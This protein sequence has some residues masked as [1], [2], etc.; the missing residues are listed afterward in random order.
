MPGGG[1]KGEASRDPPGS[2]RDRQ[3]PR[4]RDGAVFR[5]P[6]EL[7][8]DT[9]GLKAPSTELVWQEQPEKAQDQELVR[10][11]VGAGELSLGQGGAATPSRQGAEAEAGT[12]LLTGRSRLQKQTPRLTAGATLQSS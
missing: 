1:G 11:L 9:V 7:N 8:R 6:G 10:E 2:Q 12:Q 3:D 4:G 5:A